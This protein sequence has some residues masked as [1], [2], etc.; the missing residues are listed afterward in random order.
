MGECDVQIAPA[1]LETMN[2]V[3]TAVL[4][5]LTADYARYF[6]EVTA[7][8]TITSVTYMPRR[9]SDI[10]HVVLTC[11]GWKTSVYVKV[12]KKPSSPLERVRR[13]AR[14]EFDTLLHLY[15]KFQPI[16]GCF[17]VRP[18][19]FFADEMA[20]VTEQAEGENLHRLLKQQARFWQ[21]HLA[22]EALQAHCH[23]A[24]VWLRHF[25]TFT[26]QPQRQT[27]PVGDMLLQIGADMEVCV[28]MGLSRQLARRVL[29]F[30]GAQL[31]AVACKDYA[32]VGEHPDFQPDNILL[33]ATGVTVLDFTS[34]RHGFA[35]NDLTRFLVSLDFFAKHPLYRAETFRPL[36]IAFLQGYGLSPAEIDGG[37]LVYMVRYMV[38]AAR[39]VRSWPYAKWVK[40]MVER[41]TM[42]F[43]ATWCRRVLKMKEAFVAGL[44]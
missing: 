8:P 22:A 34:F 31:D 39:T 5:K 37:L 13:K 9:L 21:A 20:V 16:P 44:I 17:V 18:I 32:V 4:Q 25:H 6:P 19:A 43:L 12:H 29:H 14:L 15:D 2:G 38:Q 33:S 27:L 41:Q 36:K 26:T 3:M 40:P 28:D 35:Y 24:G 7:A 23:A 10:A 11:D 42:R 30:C 1:T